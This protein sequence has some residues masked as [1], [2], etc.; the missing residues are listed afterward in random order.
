MRLILLTIANVF[1]LQV[2]LF[3]QKKCE[4][5]VK[6]ED[7]DISKCAVEEWKSDE[8]KAEASQQIELVSVE[9]RSRKVRNRQSMSELSS[10][11]SSDDLA[12]VN[13][14]TETIEEL[15]LEKG[16][17]V[18]EVLPFN[19]VE[20]VP[21]LGK[22]KTQSDAKKCF[23]MEVNK[24][25]QRNFKY[26]PEAYRKGVQGRV[27][28]SFV[29]DKLGH[30]TD[31]SMRAPKDTEQL[32]QEAKRIISKIPQMTAGKQ[33]GHFVNVKYGIPITFRIQN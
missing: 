19:I 22:C 4:N 11:T 7:K 9:R 2:G 16:K 1:L 12:D 20:E 14:N 26:P 13:A 32:Q 28:V 5:E 18:A 27:L 25:I 33:N 30:V 31:I 24:H 10:I 15:V 6:V 23:V 3:A 17:N 8:K 21:I 29:I